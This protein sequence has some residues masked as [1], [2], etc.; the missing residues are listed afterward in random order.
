MSEWASLLRAV[1][2][3]GCRS[4][5][6]SAPRGWRKQGRLWPPSCCAVQSSGMLSGT[7]F[8]PVP[9]QT[10]C[11]SLPTEQWWRGRQ[12]SGQVCLTKSESQHHRT[13]RLLGTSGG[14]L[15][16]SRDTQNGLPSTTSSRLLKTSRRSPTSQSPLCLLTVAGAWPQHSPVTPSSTQVLSLPGSE[17]DAGRARKQPGDARG[18]VPD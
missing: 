15:V 18:T 2:Q 17:G 9:S 1:F 16:P 11:F 5:P 7:L 8:F 13:L 14:H 6:F 10:C 12:R 4:V 3:V